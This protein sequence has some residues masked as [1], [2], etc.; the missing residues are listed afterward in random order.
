MHT[1]DRIAAALA[2]LAD[3]LTSRPVDPEPTTDR[4]L[5]VAQARERLGGISRSTFYNLVGRHELRSLSV[6]SRRFVP[7]SAVREFIERS[8]TAA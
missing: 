1:E 2:E 5:T 6:G 7:E 8:A 3:A 4:L